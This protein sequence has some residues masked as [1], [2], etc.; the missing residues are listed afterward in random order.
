MSARVLLVDDEPS[1]LSTLKRLLRHQSYALD[2][3]T[4]GEQALELLGQQRYD[5]IVSDM[6]MPGMSGAELLGRAREQYPMTERILLTGYSDME[7]TIQAINDGGIFGYVSKPWDP[8]QLVA[9]IASGIEKT[10]KNK[11][12]NKVLHQLKKKTDALASD[13]EQ[14]SREVA[15]T[16]ALMDFARKQLDAKQQA[17][18]ALRQESEQAQAAMA[19]ALE[20][21]Y[22]VVEQLLLNLM[23]LKL[24]GQRVF[25]QRVADVAVALAESI[26]LDA[27]KVTRLRRAARLHGL[28]KIGVSE[29]ILRKALNQ[30]DEEELASYRQYPAHGACALMALAPFQEVAQ[31]LFNQREYLDGSGF[32]SGLTAE[33]LDTSSR[34]LALAI[35]YVEYRMGHQTGSMMTHDDCVNM[36]QRFAKRYDERLLVALASVTLEIEAQG[37][38]KE[39]VLPVHSLTE[40]MVLNKDIVS[41]AGILLLRRGTVLNE[42]AIRHMLRLQENLIER[43]MVSV[44]FQAGLPKEGEAASFAEPESAG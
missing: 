33:T 41:E 14:K 29:V 7:D 16:A 44:R 26:C 4:G 27:V 11:K 23:D 9:L 1:V 36:L 32:P 25:C 10:R 8:E 42:S 31:L 34:I 22:L 3:A 21:S 15:Q 40:N 20:D 38:G 2:T 28:G 39:L 12:K 24:R 5:L 13:V 35:D 37:E 30:L 43:L 6:R 17:E 19:Q 18:S